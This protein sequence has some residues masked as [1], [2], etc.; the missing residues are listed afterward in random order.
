VYALA[1]NV[2]T[3]SSVIDDSPATVPSTGWPYGVPAKTSACR[4]S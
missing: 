3:S 1:T 2:F 4:R